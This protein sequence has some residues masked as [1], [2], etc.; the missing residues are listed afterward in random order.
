MLAKIGSAA[1][2]KGVALTGSVLE[3]AARWRVWNNKMTAPMPAD[4]GK[5]YRLFTLGVFSFQGS[6][7]LF[8]S[9]ANDPAIRDVRIDRVILVP[10]K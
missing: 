2:H 10:V 3:S 1:N 4:P 6:Y 8:I 9:A 7:D 5:G